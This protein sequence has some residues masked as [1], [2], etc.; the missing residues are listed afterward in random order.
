MKV[1]AYIATLLVR[2]FGIYMLVRS[3]IAL[4]ALNAGGSP[5]DDQLATLVVFQ[6]GIGAVT[7]FLAGRIVRLFTADA[8]FGNE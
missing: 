3:I 5:M 6:I 1:A 4:I 2:L 7:T 8:P